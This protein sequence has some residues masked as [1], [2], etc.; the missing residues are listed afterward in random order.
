MAIHCVLGEPVL[1][2]IVVITENFNC[3]FTLSFELHLQPVD[4]CIL[5]NQAEKF[6]TVSCYP[7]ISS[8]LGWTEEMGTWSFMLYT[9]ELGVGN[10]FF[11]SFIVPVSC[12]PAPAVSP[13]NGAQIAFQ[14]LDVCVHNLC[15]PFLPW[16]YGVPGLVLSQLSTMISNSICC[17]LRQPLP[18]AINNICAPGFQM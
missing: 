12:D 2:F 18:S 6:Q 15:L 10:V 7:L 5:T 8:V 11:C 16:H 17:F 9:L 4:C 1:I 3:M 14:P 13:K